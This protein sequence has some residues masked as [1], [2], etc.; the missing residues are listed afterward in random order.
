MNNYD[1]WNARK[2][3]D[4]TAEAIDLRDEQHEMGGWI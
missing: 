2:R 3:A 1:Q 4:Q